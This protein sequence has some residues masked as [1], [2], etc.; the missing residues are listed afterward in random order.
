MYLL[1]I[2]EHW[3]ETKKQPGN[4]SREPAKSLVVQCIRVNPR[5]QLPIAL[6]LRMHVCWVRSSKDER[7]QAS[8]ASKTSNAA[9]CIVEAKLLNQ[10]SDHGWVDD[11]SNT[12]TACNNAYCKRL[13]PWEPSRSNCERE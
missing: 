10:P 12:G 8:S 13:V 1:E 2:E 5:A 6:R 9:D 3:I 11:T 4:C 7:K